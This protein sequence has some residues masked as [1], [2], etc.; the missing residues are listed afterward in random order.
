LI[1]N[2]IA[3]EVWDVGA[4]AFWGVGGRSLFWVVGGAIA[5]WM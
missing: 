5:F 3:F 2:A 4:I 1:G